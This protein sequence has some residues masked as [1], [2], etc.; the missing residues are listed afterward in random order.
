M[1]KH[2][3]H[4]QLAHIITSHRWFSGGQ[5]QKG[6]HSMPKHK[7]RWIVRLHSTD[8]RF[9]SQSTHSA[10]NR[11]KLMSKTNKKKKTTECNRAIYLCLFS[12]L[13]CRWFFE[14][15]FVCMRMIFMPRW[16]HCWFVPIQGERIIYSEVYSI[17]SSLFIYVLYFKHF[18]LPNQMT[19]WLIWHSPNIVTCG[20]IKN[21]GISE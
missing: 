6:S 10:E 16:I 20:T 3:E 12:L 14:L 11:V 5:C 1:S 8:F 2:N 15:L 7:Q 19:R 18:I 17:D 13:P 9:F 21:G 4:K